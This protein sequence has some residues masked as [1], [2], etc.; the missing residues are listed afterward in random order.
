MAMSWLPTDG[1]GVEVLHLFV[2]SPGHGELDVVGWRARFRDLDGWT[3]HLAGPQLGRFLS[4]VTELALGR[5]VPGRLLVPELFAYQAQWVLPSL[6]RAVLL[7]GAGTD[8]FER[9]VAEPDE[10]PAA[11]LCTTCSLGSDYSALRTASAWCTEHGHSPFGEYMGKAWAA[12]TE[13][14]EVRLESW[15]ARRR[16]QG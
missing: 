15:E 16:L 12:A 2:D 11:P 5:A 9:L 4:E 10:V 6:Q 7:A 8:R 3:R 14:H 13:L 1:D